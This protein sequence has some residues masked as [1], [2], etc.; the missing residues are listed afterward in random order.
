[1]FGCASKTAGQGNTTPGC[2][3]AG[4]TAVPYGRSE[5]LKVGEGT[6]KCPGII[7]AHLASYAGQEMVTHS[8]PG[9]SE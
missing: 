7:G 9:L 6:T 4:D 3:N 5:T 8:K 1:M 2:L